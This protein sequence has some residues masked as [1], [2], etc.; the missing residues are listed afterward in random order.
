MKRSV[1]VLVS[2]VV[3]AGCA[4]KPTVSENQ[5]YAG[6][7]QT[8]GYRDGASGTSSTRLLAHQD[9]CGAFGIV[10]DRNG[11]LTGW[12][13][14]LQNFC[15]A[16]S[17]FQLGLRGAGLNTVCSDELREPFASAYADGRE[18]Y[19]ARREVNRLARQLANNEHRLDQIKLDMVG[20]T[21]AQL[22]SDITVEERIILL[23]RL[24]SLAD[25]RAEIRVQQPIIEASLMY[26]EDRLADLD[27]SLASR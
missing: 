3:L 16:D 26:A 6:D 1:A 17:G 4:A 11:Y 10:P 19:T 24:E 9:A 18:F 5:C 8:I 20:V 15:T 27:Q 7:W 23:A 13:D 25:E 22:T 2:L 12:R 14:G 21:T